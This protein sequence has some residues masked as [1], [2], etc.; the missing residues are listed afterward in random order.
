MSNEIQTVDAKKAIALIINQRPSS[1]RLT[2]FS[3]LE[4]GFESETV[5]SVSIAL[6]LLNSPDFNILFVIVESNVINDENMSF[7]RL[8]RL[9]SHN[10][11]LPIFFR[12]TSLSH[13][14]ELLTLEY[15]YDVHFVRNSIVDISQ[16][17]IMAFTQF[18]QDDS[19]VSEDFPTH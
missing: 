13:E 6:E 11:N 4:W 14:L 5:H 15:D 8:A 12:T 2:Q 16:K 17:S 3:L 18:L 1:A 10:K 9:T 7:P 19:P